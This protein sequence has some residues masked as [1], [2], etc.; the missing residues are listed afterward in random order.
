MRTNVTIRHIDGTMTAEARR[1]SENIITGDVQAIIGQLESLSSM[2]AVTVLV[3]ALTN[4]DSIIGMEDLRPLR[5]A[6]ALDY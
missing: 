1:L 2:A 6:C 5:D 3:D 4:I